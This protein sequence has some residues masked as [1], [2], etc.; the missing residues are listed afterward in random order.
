MCVCGKGETLHR[1]VRVPAL[2]AGLVGLNVCVSH[3][4][5]SRGRLSGQR[6]QQILEEEIWVWDVR[7]E[8]CETNGKSSFVMTANM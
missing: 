6:V 2:V 7:E 1:L 8:T 4:G 3:E 5:V